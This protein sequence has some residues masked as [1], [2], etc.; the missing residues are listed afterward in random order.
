MEEQITVANEPERAR[1]ALYVDGT[2]AG[3]ITSTW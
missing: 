1:Y 2:R 3:M